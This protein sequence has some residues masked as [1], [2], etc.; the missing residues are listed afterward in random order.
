MAC[1]TLYTF[2]N[3]FVFEYFK[4][5]KFTLTWAGKYTV[6]ILSHLPPSQITNWLW[7]PLAAEPK[8]IPRILNT[9]PQGMNIFE[10]PFCLTQTA[11]IK[12]H[13]MKYSRLKLWI[14]LKKSNWISWTP[15]FLLLMT[16]ISTIGLIFWW[17]DLENI[18]NLSLVNVF[19]YQKPFLAIVELPSNYPNSIFVGSTN[20]F[21]S[22]S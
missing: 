13:C 21:S 20:S 18:D 15:M 17:L 22:L 7:H 6:W 2:E 16:N 4:L 3:V 10:G 11:I 9:S 8:C 5:I 1:Q 19:N 14:Q 12:N